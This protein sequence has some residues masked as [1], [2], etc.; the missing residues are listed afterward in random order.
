MRLLIFCIVVL[1]ISLS[2]Q[3]NYTHTIT[4]GD[5]LYS[6]SFCDSGSFCMAFKKSTWIEINLKKIIACDT[7][8]VG[9]P[10]DPTREVQ[11]LVVCQKSISMIDTLEPKS[12]DELPG[13]LKNDIVV[14][15]GNNKVIHK[16]I[17]IQIFDEYYETMSFN[18][19]NLNMNDIK[20]FI[21]NRNSTV[22]LRI[23]KIELEEEDMPKSIFVN[24]AFRLKAQIDDCPITL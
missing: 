16:K 6:G 23:L 17:R 19:E 21:K 22:Y 1:P 8:P 9:C 3:R 7:L 14:F 15:R 12:I 13:F 18:N 20:S 5:S 10:Q 24:V 11:Y 4:I 2:A